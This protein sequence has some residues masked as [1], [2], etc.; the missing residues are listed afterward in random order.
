MAFA[1]S[2]LI[3][4]SAALFF[5]M[6]ATA[7][8]GEPPKAKSE[9]AAA[10]EAASP[11]VTTPPPESTAPASTPEPSKEDSK[12][13]EE[14]K[15]LLERFMFQAVAY[16]YLGFQDDVD[17]TS[18][19]YLFGY[20]RWSPNHT[21]RLSQPMTKLYDIPE[22]DDELLLSDTQIRHTWKVTPDLWQGF[23]LQAKPEITIPISEYSREQSVYTKPA[24]TLELRRSFFDGKLDLILYGYD[25]EYI[26]EYR[27]T[28]TLTGG[29]GGSPMRRR[30]NGLG[31]VVGYNFSEKLGASYTLE[32]NEIRYEE[33]GRRNREAMAG[34]RNIFGH[35]YSFD[36]SIT[37]EL[38]HNFFGYLGYAQEDAVERGGG[39]E[40]NA[41]DPVVSQW[42]IALDYTLDFKGNGKDHKPTDE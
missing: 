8:Q 15:T 22:G 29:S 9:S 1:R 36:A 40:I 3:C 37:Y 2:Y 30:Q 25:R 17:P 31:H 10:P 32:Y 26:N 33:V 16:H 41:F 39:L 11:A 28:R 19:F 35:N 34:G 5:A 38:M 4:T 6:P 14:P 20:Y 18:V 12:P 42:Y 23:A 7:Q 27:T 24:L 13:A 21:T